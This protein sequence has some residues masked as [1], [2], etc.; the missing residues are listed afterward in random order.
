MDPKVRKNIIYYFTTDIFVFLSIYMSFFTL[1]WITFKITESP[2]SLGIVGFFLNI[3]F[4][5]F[6]VYG[7]VL[8]DKYDKRKNVIKCNIALVIH[9]IGLIV[10]VLLNWLSYPAILIFTFL[11]GSIMS[12]NMPSMIGLVKDYIKDKDLFPKIMGA[13]ASNMK[14]GEIVSSSTFT[15]IF[16][17]LSAT[18]TF[19]ISLAGNLISLF[20]ITRLKTESEIQNV[21]TDSAYTQMV[22]GIKYVMKYKPLFALTLVA[23]VI[24]T[25]FG[26]VTFQLPVIDHNF[27]KGGA[28]YLG[29]LYFAGAVGGLIAGIYMGKRKS[30]KN[31]IRFLYICCFI[32]GISIIGLSFSRSIEISFIFAMGVDFAFVAALG[33]NNTVLQ[34]LT[35]DSIRGRVLGVNTS[36]NLGLMAI[37]IMLLGFLA[38]SIGSEIVMQ[39]SGAAAIISGILYMISIKRQR[40]ILD[41]IYKERG[42]EAGKEPI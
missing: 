27:L 25:V 4:L 17:L 33:I 11:L 10:F 8:A 22:T 5:I 3:P 40:P 9:S 20:A 30:T 13:A 12:L 38:G 6:S 42:I 37:F 41:Q 39:I 15:I 2:S 14:I 21:K 1:T 28:G 31:I 29:I 7:G 19:I 24:S 18:G 16:S 36:F 23:T 35:E 32:S 26:Y 34:I